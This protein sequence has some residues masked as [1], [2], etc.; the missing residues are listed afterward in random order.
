MP[1][2]MRLAAR[3]DIIE[4]LSALGNCCKKTSQKNTTRGRCRDATDKLQ[5]AL[6]SWGREG[7][8]AQDEGLPDAMEVIRSRYKLAASHMG[9]SALGNAGNNSISF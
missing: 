6:E 4:V 5:R 7:I 8:D 3:L 9:V 2:E 1:R